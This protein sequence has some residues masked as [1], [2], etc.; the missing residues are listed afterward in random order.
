MQYFFEERKQKNP[1]PSIWLVA[2]EEIS[3]TKA[4]KTETMSLNT[5]AWQNTDILI[6]SVM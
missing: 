6:F 5:V 2:E 1:F 4:N 3:K